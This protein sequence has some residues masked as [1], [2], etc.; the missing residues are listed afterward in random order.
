MGALH[1]GLR[2]GGERGNDLTDVAGGDQRGVGVGAVDHYLQRRSTGALQGALEPRG[3]NDTDDRAPLIDVALERR[4]ARGRIDDAE[5]SAGDKMRN[6]IATSLAAVEVEYRGG[7]VV[8]GEGRGVAEQEQLDDQGQDETHQQPAVTP[9]LPELLDQHGADAIEP[10]GIHGLLNPDSCGT[11]AP[12]ANRRRRQT[13][14][15]QAAAARGRPPC[16]P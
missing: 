10:D 2:V 1:P 7:D 16:C 14:T 9:Q 5:A 4:L 12:P 6:Q 15:T 3:D 8:Y 13:C 11:R